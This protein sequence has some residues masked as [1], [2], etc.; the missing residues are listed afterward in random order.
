MSNGFGLFRWAPLL[1]VALVALPG[2]ALDGVTFRLPGAPP[3]LAATLRAASL[4]ETARR[5]G[6]ADAQEVFAAAQADY[7]RLLGAL[8]AA[9]HY[10]GTISIRV[11]GREAANIAPL[12][13]PTTIRQIEIEVRPGPPFRFGRAEAAPLATGTAL[14][15]GFATGAPALSGTIRAAA[16]A[17]V[18]GWRD[19]GHAKARVGDQSLTAD[20]PRAV[21]DARLA[22]APG[23]QARFGRLTFTGHA[24]MREARLLKIAGLTPGAVYSPAELRKAADRLRRTGVFRSVALT[25]AEALGPGATLDITANVVEMPWRRLGFGA[26]LTSTEGGTLSAFW[27]HRNLRG[28]G[29]RFRIELEA[30][31]IGLND[32][33]IDWTLGVELERPAT[34][35]PDT[36]ARLTFDLGRDQMRQARIDTLAVG[37]GLRHIFNERLTGRAD[38]AYSVSRVSDTTGRRSFRSLSLPVGLTW[39]R[40]DTALDTRRG[41]WIDAEAMPFV[42]FGATGSGLRGT[43]DARGFYPVGERVV[44]AARLQGGIITGS[45]LTDTPRNYLFWSGGGGTVRGQPFRSLG[46]NIGRMITGG[47]QFIGGSVEVRGKVTDSIG[48]VGFFDYGRITDSR[49]SAAPA[50]NWHAGAGVGVRYATPVGPIRLDIAAPAGGRKGGG[51]Q[52][53]LGIGQA[54]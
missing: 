37:F 42:G 53:Y 49:F 52:F 35:T 26:E 9:G 11:D 5:E 54:F 8:Y 23:P 16:E 46:V 50:S 41:F 10:S 29:E 4:T 48:V 38:I 36:T 27:L 25:E 43:L 13:A 31:H 34:F 39:D 2:H 6:R 1:L 12:N 17:A 20:H 7:G 19:A 32:G 51:V 14:P 18:D 44:L 3:D 15:E 21:L 22:L 33:G 24:R 40:R 28:G 47:T 45:D 30:T